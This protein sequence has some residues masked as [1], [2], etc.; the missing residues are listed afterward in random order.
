MPGHGITIRGPNISDSCL[1]YSANKNALESWPIRAHLASQ[2]DELCKN[3][4]VLERWSNN[5]AHYVENNV[6]LNFKPH[7]H[8]ALHQIMFFLETSYDPFNVCGW[9]VYSFVIVRNFLLMSWKS[10]KKE[11]NGTKK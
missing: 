6:F 11:I 8:I 9:G 2:N 5:N 10:L 7:R 4:R 3:R 1:R